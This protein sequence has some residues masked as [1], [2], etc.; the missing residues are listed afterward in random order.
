MFLLFRHLFISF[1][2]T[3]SF[4]TIGDV[5]LGKL[6]YFRIISICLG[7]IEDTIED[8]VEDMVYEEYLR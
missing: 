3:I 5:T 4:H 2:A 8:A 7:A 1:P 6:I